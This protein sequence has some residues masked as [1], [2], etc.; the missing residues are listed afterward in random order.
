MLKEPTPKRI[1]G[2]TLGEEVHRFA[3]EQIEAL[4]GCTEDAPEE[5]ELIHWA[6]LADAYER[7]AGIATGECSVS[8]EARLA[9][10]FE[11]SLSLTE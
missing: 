1:D 4:A 2:R 5:R 7:S 11:R 10:S 8:G 9:S 6:T 3:L